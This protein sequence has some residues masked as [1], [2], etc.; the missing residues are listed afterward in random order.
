M[1]SVDVVDVSVVPVPLKEPGEV[2]VGESVGGGVSWAHACEVPASAA[3]PP[4]ARAKEKARVRDA[5]LVQD[6]VWRSGRMFSP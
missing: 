1:A 2:T 5:G 3:I 6:A 4:A